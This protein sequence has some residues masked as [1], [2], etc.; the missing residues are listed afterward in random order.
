ML[1]CKQF[2]LYLRYASAVQCEV[3]LPQQSSPVC[4]LTRTAALDQNKKIWTLKHD[5][6]SHDFA[7]LNM[8]SLQLAAILLKDPFTRYYITLY[9]QT[10]SASSKSFDLYK[11]ITAG[12]EITDISE[13]LRLTAFFQSALEPVMGVNIVT[14]IKRYWRYN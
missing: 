9:S 8:S 10:T 6:A 14:S 5:P 3:S 13:H 11:N 12:Q 1:I 7:V 4:K 2:N